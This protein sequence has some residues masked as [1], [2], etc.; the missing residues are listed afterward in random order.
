MKGSALKSQ[1]PQSVEEVLTPEQ[2]KQE[3]TGNC[4]EN[5]VTILDRLVREGKEAVLVQGRPV[6][7]GGKFMGLRYGHAWVEEV[8]H[9]SL[10]GKD[11]PMVMCH[12][13]NQLD[14][15]LPQG[16]YYWAGGIREE[17]NKRFTFEEVLE[18]IHIEG[19]YGP[20]EV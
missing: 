20:W 15:C 5:A 1:T 7:Q 18:H 16:L 10:Q 19:H 3:A 17:D 4:Y 8:E 14:T 6:L 11:Y 9:H 12:D 2:L 13:G